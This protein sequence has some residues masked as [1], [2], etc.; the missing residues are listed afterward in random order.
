MP[1]GHIARKRFGQNFLSDAN[2]IRKI[3]AAIAPRP[4]DLLVEIGPGLG[5]LTEPL[6]AASEHLH[7]VEIDRDLI[8]RL[9]EKHDPAHLTIH[10]GDALKFDFGTLG[11]PLR[12]VGNLPYNISTPILFHLAG[13]AD[14]VR[15]M[16]FMLQKEV[17]DRMVAEPDT[18]A[19]GRLSVMLQYRFNM[20]SLFDVPPGAFRPAPK[21][22]SAIV[23]LQ[24]KPAAECVCTDEALLGRIVTAAFGQRRKTLRN[25]L[26]EWLKEEDFVALGIDPQARGETLGV[27]DYVRMVSH[28]SSHTHSGAM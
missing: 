13:Y 28:L 11:S 7:V 23:Y 14:Q 19:Y 25:T 15:D 4:G 9:K 17:V 5:A 26:R 10:E 24:P 2:I 21:V 27:A 6:L 8:A 22:T 18:E 20:A 1:Q 3:V 16:T 12:V